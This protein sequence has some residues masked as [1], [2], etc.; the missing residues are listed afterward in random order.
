MGAGSENCAYLGSGIPNQPIDTWG[1][2]SETYTPS[3]RR[4]ASL[5][6]EVSMA[7]RK[8]RNWI[9]PVAALSLA[10]ALLVAVPS[11]NGATGSSCTLR[12]PT[13]SAQCDLIT[14]ALV[15]KVVTLDPTSSVR[16][17][18]QNYITKFLVQ[19]A[20]WR[21]A[22]D[23]KPK[24]DLVAS[25]TVSADGL[26]W[27]IKM[28]SGIKYSDGVTPV[29]ADDAVFMWDLLK[30]APPPVFS[31]VKTMTSSDA[32]TLVVT[33]KSKFAE[34]PYALSSIYFFVNPRAKAEGN[35]DYWKNPLSA[36]PYKIKSWTPGNDEFLVE[37][38]SQYWAVPAVKSIRFLAVPDPVTRVIALKQGT[39]DYAFDLP[40]AIARGQLKAT[41]TF[42]GIPVK[43]QGTFTLDFNLRSMTDGKPWRNV[44]VRQAL[45]MAIDRKQMGNVAFFGDVKPGCS[46]TWAS[47]DYAICK[48][49]DGLKQNIDGAKALLKAAGYEAGFPINLTV[50]NRPGWSDAAALVAADWKKIGVTATVIPQADAVG[51]AA[52]SSGDFQVQFSGATGQIATLI[53][54]T[55]YGKTGAWTVW[56]GSGSNDAWMDDI[57]AAD[58]ANKRALIGKVE[59]AMWDESA[60]IPLGQRSVYGATRLPKD[61]FQNVAG[62]DTYYVKQTPALS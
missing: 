56:S 29:T 11:A 15:N 50:F 32:S 3:E 36:G 24:Y 54:R 51:S 45:S 23:G 13:D 19:G 7:I 34:L 43:L 62:N 40:A 37:A 46:I 33:L 53:L 14:V 25:H 48:N 9:A 42:R 8:L 49:P 39:I 26:T 55:Y 20:L 47:S 61:I 27:T 2:L 30:A 6:K 57:D 28:K 58:P 60:H 31:G 16:T 52:Q 1:Y 18:N 35:A 10:G 41:S 12:T 21:V 4:C 5:A 59:Q 22:S 17:T 44:K 38:N